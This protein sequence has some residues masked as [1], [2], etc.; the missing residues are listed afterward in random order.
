MYASVPANKHHTLPYHSRDIVGRE[1]EINDLKSFLQHGAPRIVSIT[2]GP[3][4]GKSTLAIAVGNELETEGVAVI[5][6]NLND[7]ITTKYEIATKI[8]FRIDRGSELHK[9]LMQ[10]LMDWSESLSSKTLLILDN[11]DEHFHVEKDALQSLI[12]RLLKQSKHL[13][14]LTTSRRQVAYIEAHIYPASRSVNS[15]SH[16]QCMSFFNCQ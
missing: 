8:I 1:N 16:Q 7:E 4:F 14:V 15:L 11:C 3:G 9:D 13:K 10:K 12:V 5:Y 6:V 2:G